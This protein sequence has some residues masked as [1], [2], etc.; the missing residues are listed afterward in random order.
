MYILSKPN[1][2]YRGDACKQQKGGTRHPH[3]PEMRFWNRPPH[4]GSKDRLPAPR[5]RCG[6]GTK[7]PALRC[8]LARNRSPGIKWASILR[9]GHCDLTSELEPRHG[10]RDV[11]SKPK[12]WHC[13]MGMASEPRSK[14]EH[15]DGCC[16]GTEGPALRCDLGTEAPALRCDLE[17]KAPALR[18]DLG[19]EAP[20]LRRDLGTEAP[21]LRCDLGTEAP[22]LS[23][24]TRCDL[25]TETPALRRDLGTEAPALR[26]D[27]SEPKPGHCDVTSEQKP[28]NCVESAIQPC[29]YL[30][31][32]SK[33]V[34]GAGTSILI[35]HPDA[36]TLLFAAC[37]HHLCRS[38]LALIIYT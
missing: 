13:D 4:P 12:P 16:L 29:P 6:P 15:C 36:G 24:A 2:I 27:R 33:I 17:T 35:L 38:H 1:E 26:C 11:T 14:P 7:T 28:R 10:H 18:S 20:A 9:S 8:D 3:V 30:G 23:I 5:M 32:R 34:S 19:T 22:A 21:A 31:S 37:M 25:G